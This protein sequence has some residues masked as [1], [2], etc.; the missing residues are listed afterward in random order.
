MSWNLLEICKIPGIMIQNKYYTSIFISVLLKQ[1]I[2]LQTEVGHGVQ[3]LEYPI[4]VLIHTW[5]LTL[6]WMKK[7]IKF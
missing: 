1:I 5:Q 4:T 3:L 2:E 6:K 7:M